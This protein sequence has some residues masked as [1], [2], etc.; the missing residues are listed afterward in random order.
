MELDAI[1]I[2]DPAKLAGPRIDSQL[3]HSCESTISFE[4]SVDSEVFNFSKKTTM[5]EEA[6]KRFQEWV[7]AA[8]TN[9][10]A[11]RQNTKLSPDMTRTIWRKSN[12]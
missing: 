10:A 9:R 4:D 8:T 7:G 2:H 6:E 3:D 12:K 5:G 1:I 11:N